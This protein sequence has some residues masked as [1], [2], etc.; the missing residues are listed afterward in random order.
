MYLILAIESALLDGILLIQQIL[1]RNIFFCVILIPFIYEVKIS[2]K[3]RKTKIGLQEIYQFTIGYFLKMLIVF[4]MASKCNTVVLNFALAKIAVNGFPLIAFIRKLNFKIYLALILIYSFGL[5]LNIFT[6]KTAI[7]EFGLAL[8]QTIVYYLLIDYNTKYCKEK[9]DKWKKYAKDLFSVLPMPII[10]LDNNNCSKFMNEEAFMIFDSYK[11]M[12]KGSFDIFLKSF[13]ELN[14]NT[15]TLK[16]NMK[17]FRDNIIISLYNRNLWSKDY[18]IEKDNSPESKAKK[19][20]YQ[21]ILLQDKH[22][23]FIPDISNELLVLLIDVSDRQYLTEHMALENTKS[24][25]IS[26]MSHELRTPL[27]GIIGGKQKTLKQ[28]KLGEKS[29]YCEFPC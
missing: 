2:V 26:T 8:S 20:Y 14:N 18:C 23:L 11:H 22:S 10:A 12:H 19:K 13:Y 28:P 7:Y 6:I 24:I 29:K 25:L 1:E 9:I 4:Y 16:D 15:T 3:L 5:L 21:V 27:N 17:E